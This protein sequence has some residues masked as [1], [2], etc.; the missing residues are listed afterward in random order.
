M[1]LMDIFP[2]ENTRPIQKEVMQTIL[3]G[4]ENKQGI[5]IHAPTGLGKTVA[6]IA[7]ALHTALKE[8]KTVF[9][10]TSRNT[11]HKIAMDTIKAIRDN[12]KLNITATDIIG[13]KWM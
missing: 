10:L 6:S 9:F 8:K 1:L 13:K 12:K 5:V 11:Q 4:V 2:Y 7:P 3:K